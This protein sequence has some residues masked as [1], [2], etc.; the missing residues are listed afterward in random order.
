MFRLAN[1][2]EENP[3]EDSLYWY[4]SGAISN[5]IVDCLDEYLENSETYDLF[6]QYTIPEDFFEDL[7]RYVLPKTLCLDVSRDD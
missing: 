5:T 3:E 6:F 7:S 2:N 4:L 1:F